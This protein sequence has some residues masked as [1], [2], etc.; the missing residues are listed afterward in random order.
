LTVTDQNGCQTSQEK[1]MDFSTLAITENQ[2]DDFQLFPNPV[3]DELHVQT[4]SPMQ[5]ITIY[6]TVVSII[7]HVKVKESV[8]TLN[9]SK[10]S[11]GTYIIEVQHQNGSI[12]VQRL[13]K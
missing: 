10:L 6:S 9:T 2:F 1:S 11:R 5:S 8:T 12:Q 13:V 3:N 4:S 7:Q